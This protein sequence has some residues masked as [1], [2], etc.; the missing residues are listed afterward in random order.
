MDSFLNSP[1]TTFQ[2][3]I[4]A[5]AAVILFN[6]LLVIVFGDKGLVDLFRMKSEQAQ[7]QKKTDAI[8]VENLKMAREIER[9]QNDDPALIEHRARTQLGMVKPGEIVVKVAPKSQKGGND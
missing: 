5:V 1:L 7:I 4:I 2:K 6:F 9:L 8:V 3:A